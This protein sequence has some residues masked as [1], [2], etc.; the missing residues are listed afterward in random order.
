M[1]SLRARLVIGL[2][3]VFAVVAAP[4]GWLT[5]QRMLD[6]TSA[7][8][9]YQLRQMALSLRDQGQVPAELRPGG[10]D[11][12]FVIQ[13]WDLFGTRIYLSR[14][15]L[16]PI[17]Q[18][19]LGYSDLQ[20]QGEH[21]RVF[22][23]QTPGRVI[24]VAQPWKVREQLAGQAAGRALLPLLAFP[25]LMTIAIWL[26]VTRALKPLRRVAQDVRRLDAGS[27]EPVS[28]RDVPPEVE[29]LVVELNRL[30]GRLSR[31]IDTQRAFV[32]DAAH[33]LRTPLTALRLNLQLL[34]R[35]GADSTARDSAIAQLESAIER[36]THLVGQLL[37]L[38]RSEP[39][40]STPP[41]A[42]M[43][44][45]EAV[46]AG[47]ADAAPLA[48][49]RGSELECE[50]ETPVTIRGDAD[51]IRIA[52][53]NLCDN[54]LRYSPAGS[55]VRVAVDA[56]GRVS[57]DDSGPGIPAEERERVF[58]RFYR[59]SG[60]AEGGSGLGLAIVRAI[61]DRHDASLFCD[62]SVFGGLHVELR[63]SPVT[64]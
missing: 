19:I 34:A 33:E 32:G 15:G 12:D 20:L 3:L 54:A 2:A 26:I 23:L 18:A 41:A 56:Q 11:G 16:P 36:A 9:D 45:D 13:I 46:R 10:A 14:P 5:Y 28:T 27:L 38:A 57:V 62:T 25:L 55:R 17:N 52:V 47:V 40:S 7:L 39:G 37:T 6:E 48:L 43:R 31:A 64:R 60:S 63:F 58:D 44:L 50:A 35:S 8:F 24:Q 61:A 30:L 22:G 29:P 21:W 51:A 59:R 42:T 53:R 49:S 1:I 4:F